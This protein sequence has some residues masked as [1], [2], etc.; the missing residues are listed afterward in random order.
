M[1]KLIILIVLAILVLSFF[2]VSLH[3]IITAPATQENFAYVWGLV[4]QGYNYVAA[5]L[6]TLSAQI[7]HAM[8]F[9]V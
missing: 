6:Q 7:N 9:K 4:M 8:P 2:G 3:S 5:W 1:L